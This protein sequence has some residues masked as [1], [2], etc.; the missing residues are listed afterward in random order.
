MDFIELALAFFLV[1]QITRMLVFAAVVRYPDIVEQ[2]LVLAFGIGSGALDG[3]PFEQYTILEG[4]GAAGLALF[5]LELYVVALKS[6]QVSI[7]RG[8]PNR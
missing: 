5:L 3:E 6:S 1:A 2:L 4:V 8:R 7:P